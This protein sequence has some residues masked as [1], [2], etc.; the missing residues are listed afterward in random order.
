VCELRK[1]FELGVSQ[2]LAAIYTDGIYFAELISGKT[3][4]WFL[5]FLADSLGEEYLREEYEDE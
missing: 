3:K 4:E 1:R 2:S 5:Q